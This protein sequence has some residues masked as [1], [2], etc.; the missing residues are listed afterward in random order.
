MKFTVRPIDLPSCNLRIG[1]LSEIKR[2]PNTVL[3]TPLLLLYSKGGSV[4]HMT[5]EVLEMVTDI[6]SQAVHIPLS[7]S[8]QC[9]NGVKHFKEGISSFAGLHEC[10]S[11]CSVQDPAEATRVGYNEKTSITIWTHTGRKQLTADKYMDMMEAFRPDMYQALCDGDTN[12]ESSRKRSQKAVDVSTSLFLSCADR[13]TK[14][15]SLKDS[16]LL[17]TVEGGYDLEARRQSAQMFSRHPLVQG[18]V[19]DGLHNNGMAVEQMSYDTIRPVITET[20]KYLPEDKL[21]VLHGCW[22]PDVVL[23][24]VQAGIDV[25][26]SSLVYLAAERGCAFTFTYHACPHPVLSNEDQCSRVIEEEQKEN[27]CIKNVT[28][29]C[30]PDDMQ[31]KTC[32]R[33]TDYEMNL[34]DKIYFD[35][36]S[37]IM[38]DCKCLACTKHTRA[39]IHHLL[40]TRE[41]LASVLL[42]IHNLHHYQKF[43]EAIRENGKK[44]QLLAINCH[45][46]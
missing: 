35:D 36:L 27:G 26:D 5:R 39:Y 32:K 24:L 17:A 15:Q 42:M 4:T 45:P 44:G 9:Y 38:R 13:H 2:I 43:F 29:N 8:A 14:S 33:I 22:R 6:S 7:N 1:K 31:T 16:A 20:L 40:N 25:F 34:N 41:M 46:S 30:K 12:T 37:P 11:Y 10:L 3:L 19:I 23:E 21:R 18:F 28:Q